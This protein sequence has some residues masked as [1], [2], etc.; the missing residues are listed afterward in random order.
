MKKLLAISVLITLFSL[1]GCIVVETKGKNKGGPPWWA[2]AHGYRN[3]HDKKDKGSTIVIIKKG[4]GHK[5]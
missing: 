4:K 3:H 1:S 2:P 5:H